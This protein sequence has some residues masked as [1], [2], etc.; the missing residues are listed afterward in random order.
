MTRIINK[1]SGLVFI[2][3]LITVWAIYSYNDTSILTSVSSISNKKIN[4]GIKRGKNHEQPDLGTTNI[5]LI[6]KYD[7]IAMGNK[8]KKYVY[9]TFDSG[10]EA[11]YT[12]EILDILKKNEVNATFFITAHYLNSASDLVERMIKEGHIIRKSY[13]KS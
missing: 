8:E 9:L 6:E 11:G 10:Y 5:E 1:L 3:M 7:G 13:S 2:L 12:E 4:W